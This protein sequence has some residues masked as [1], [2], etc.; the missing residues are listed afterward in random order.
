MGNHIQRSHRV[1]DRDQ[2]DLVQRRA[3]TT[4]W[5]LLRVI[6]VGAVLVGALAW[7]LTHLLA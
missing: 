6:V 2:S 4:V 5:L 3:F 1:T 7:T